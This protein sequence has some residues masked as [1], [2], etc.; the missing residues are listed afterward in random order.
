MSR[1]G[2]TG[3]AK[4]PGMT[5][6]GVI[7]RTRPADVAVVSA[8]LERLPGTDLVLDPGD[9]RMVV[10]IEDIDPAAE[11]APRDIVARAVF[12]SIR[13]GRGAFLDARGSIGSSFPERFP[14]V[15]RLC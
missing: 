11:L 2:R 3:L 5:V 15:Y 1:R 10:L 4:M 9:G 12:A 13:A 7:L 14:H 6:L 8:R